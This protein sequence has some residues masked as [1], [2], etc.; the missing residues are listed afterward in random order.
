MTQ[1]FSK[2]QTQA[3]IKGL[4]HEGYHVVKDDYGY[5]VYMSALPGDKRVLTAMV[6]S[7]G[8]LV[9]YE[10]TLLTPSVEV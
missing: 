5:N 6:G 9:R 10:D 1:L 4:R 8:Y 2:K 7:R 3:V